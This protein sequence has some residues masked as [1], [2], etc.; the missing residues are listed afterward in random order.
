MSCSQSMQIAWMTF[1][2]DK[3]LTDSVTVKI[4]QV[5]IDLQVKNL[6]SILRYIAWCTP[7]LEALAPKMPF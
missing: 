7:F 2:H 6:Y 1:S 5:Y 3:Q 4:Y